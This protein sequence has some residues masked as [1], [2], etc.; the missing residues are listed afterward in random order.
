MNTMKLQPRLVVPLV[1]A[2]ASGTCAPPA[3]QTAA[4]DRQAVEAEVN[5]WVQTFLDT[6]AE[7]GAGYDRGLAMFDD[8]PDFV[9]ALDGV[10]WR[11]LVPVDEMMRPIWRTVDHQVFDFPVT[12]VAVLGPDLAH[13]ALEG[14]YVQT[15][16]DGTSMGPIPYVATMLL[17]RTGGAWE[18]PV[19]PPIH[20]ER[21]GRWHMNRPA[22]LAAALVVTACASPPAG[23]GPGPGDH[24]FV[25]GGHIR[26]RDSAQGPERHRGRSLR[27]SLWP[28]RRERTHEGRG[29][30]RTCSPATPSRTR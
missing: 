15:F 5:A 14:T 22:Q 12:A 26:I 27:L 30:H 29:G 7:G 10:L 13:V 4:V 11:S 2:F 24:G 25:G 23:A 18:G 19:H 21:I 20:A 9:F 17:V 16:V 3:P 28:R 1:I 6:F 8:H